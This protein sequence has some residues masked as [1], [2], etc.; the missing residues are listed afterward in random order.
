LNTT[1]A[2]NSVGEC[3]L[4]TVEVGGSNPLPP[5]IEIARPWDDSNPGPL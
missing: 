2:V 3:H 4:H 1:W 5:T